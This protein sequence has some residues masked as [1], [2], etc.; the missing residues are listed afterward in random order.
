MAENIL[1]R[2]RFSGSI[3]YISSCRH[4]QRQFSWSLL[5][6]IANSRQSFNVVFYF[7][8]VWSIVSWYG[9]DAQHH[10]IIASSHQIETAFMV[11]VTLD[12]LTAYRLRCLGV[13][14]QFKYPFKAAGR[15]P[16]SDQDQNLTIF[17]LWKWQRTTQGQQDSCQA[18]KSKSQKAGGS[19]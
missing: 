14:W 1:F 7:Q 10:I 15:D 18:W 17:N 9:Y 3:R 11:M 19:S 12:D 6:D 13:L 5:N 4:V 8:N 2:A 16:K